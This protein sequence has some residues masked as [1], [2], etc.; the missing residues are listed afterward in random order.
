MQ[1][2]WPALL[3]AT[4]RTPRA[5]AGSLIRLDLPPVIG[6][7]A[8]N[9]MAVIS[10]IL[11]SIALQLSPVE[12]DPALMALFGSP[13]RVLMLQGLLLWTTA[14]LMHRVGAM[15]GG[16]GRFKDAVL[17]LAWAEAVLLLMQALQI[18]LLLVA[19]A[20]S[21]LMGIV[22]IGLLFWLMSSFVAELH[23][24]RSVFAVLMGM[25]STALVLSLALAI[26]ITVFIGA[27]V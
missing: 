3:T 22:A 26:L 15:F 24:F 8:L 20:L 14:V 4:V 17:V 7:T 1:P 10:A 27:G 9:L 16:S 12:A 5:V 18:L 11:A 21:D 6:A 23:G 25:F 2:D 19:P 13:L